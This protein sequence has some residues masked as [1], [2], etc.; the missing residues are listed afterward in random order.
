MLLVS[1][2]LFSVAA[3]ISWGAGFTSMAAARGATMSWLLSAAGSVCA[4]VAGARGVAGHPEQLQLGDLGGLGQAGLTIDRLSGLFLVISFAVAVPVLCT[5]ASVGH[6]ERTRLP[7]LIAAT[8]GAVEV[9]VTADHFFVLLFGWEALTVCFYLLTG[10]DRDLPGRSR[11]AVAAATF[12]KASGALLLIGGGLL[13]TSSGSLM[14]A[15]WSHATGA[16]HDAGYALLVAGF[17]VKV[18]LIP[19]QL[20]LPPSYAAAPGP[21]RAV[22]AG[23]AVNVGFY[24]MW[25]TLQVLTVP[26]EWLIVVLMLVAGLT[27][28]LGI[29]HASVNSH[30]QRLIAWS[31]VENAGVITAGYSVALIGAATN[32]PQLTAVGLVAATAQVIAHAVAKALLFVAAGHIHQAAGGDDL[33]RLRGVI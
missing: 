33:D 29:A 30:L 22:M 14:L 3:L 15:D 10:Y 9:I 5:G 2:L 4:V 8:L 23:V 17:A 12:G 32:S 31:S 6:P 13:T 11:A 1:L 21:A 18:G 27:A 20:W 26:P 28:I 24:G 25:R 7:A 16:A 19:L